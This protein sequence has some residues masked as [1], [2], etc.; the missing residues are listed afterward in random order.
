MT[1]CKHTRLTDLIALKAVGRVSYPQLHILFFPIPSWANTA[2]H[3][4]AYTWIGP[5]HCL[6]ST[7]GQRGPRVTKC[8]RLVVFAHRE[9]PS[10]YLLSLHVSFHV[11]LAQHTTVITAFSRASVVTSLIPSV[12]GLGPMRPRTKGLLAT[13]RSLNCWSSSQ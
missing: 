12:S 11:G 9:T 6:E 4:L 13:L 2:C 10:R 3:C 7:S 8:P 5:H 1:G